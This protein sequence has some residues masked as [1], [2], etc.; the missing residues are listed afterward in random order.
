MKESDNTLII[1]EL[2]EKTDADVGSNNCEHCKIKYNHSQ[3]FE[4]SVTL[5]DSG[6]PVDWWINGVHNVV[7]TDSN[8]KSAI[9]VLY[10][11]DATGTLVSKVGRKAAIEISYI[12]VPFASFDDN[13]WYYNTRCYDI[14]K[15]SSNISHTFNMGM[16]IVLKCII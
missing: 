15:Y 10:V 7:R 11:Q 1:F 5:Q 14:I 3:G 12:C 9:T 4:Y 8:E 6:I 2:A 16:W 13:V